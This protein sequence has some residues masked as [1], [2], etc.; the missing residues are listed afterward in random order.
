MIADCDRERVGGKGYFVFRSVSGWDETNRTDAWCRG[1]L[2]TRQILAQRLH[3]PAE[4]LTRQIPEPPLEPRL[5][6][7]LRR[8]T[9]RVLETMVCLRPVAVVPAQDKPC[10]H[11]DGL[12]GLLG[13][14]GT[15]RGAFVVRERERVARE[16]AASMLRLADATAVTESDARDAFGEV[17]NMLA[18][19]FK[20]AW[21]QAGNRM[22]L[23][24]PDV[25][26]DGEANVHLVGDRWVRS[27]VCAQ[28]GSGSL[29]IGV[30]FEAND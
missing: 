15:R 22:E 17:V 6:E 2:P 8:T 24:V 10:R 28:L 7:S 27:R 13:F 14:T 11:D 30:H 9:Q 16:V 23:W 1:L 12:T 19:D 4:H 20:Q 18:G 5:T 25:L 3:V 21:E 29:D 26:R